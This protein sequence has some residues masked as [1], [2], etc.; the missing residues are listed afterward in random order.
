MWP[1]CQFQVLNNMDNG[2]TE[3]NTA[4]VV[5]IINYTCDVL[6]HNYYPCTVN[7]RIDWYDKHQSRNSCIFHT[8]T[9]PFSLE[10]MVYSRMWLQNSNTVW[11][12]A[13]FTFMF[14][15]INVTTLPSQSLAPLQAS[16]WISQLYCI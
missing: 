10:Y 4:T 14:P 11:P 16:P 15:A 8:F 13:H 9:L 7:L 2:S 6:C 1:D 3:L 12:T 5:T